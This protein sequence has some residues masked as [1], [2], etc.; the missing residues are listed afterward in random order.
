MFVECLLCVCPPQEVNH[1]EFEPD[2]VA[3]NEV[4]KGSLRHVKPAGPKPAM[5]KYL[6]AVPKKPVA[7]SIHEEYWGTVAEGGGPSF[8]EDI[9][10]FA[11]DLESSLFEEDESPADEFALLKRARATPKGRGCYRN[12]HL[13]QGSWIASVIWDDEAK[14]RG[15]PS[16][17][18]LDVTADR[19]LLGGRS[20]CEQM[21]SLHTSGSS[22]FERFQMVNESNYS[23]AMRQ[24]TK[25]NI[26]GPTHSIPALSLEF[27]GEEPKRGAALEWLHR[28]IVE[29]SKLKFDFINPA[30]REIRR[31][32]ELL[33][34]GGN[35]NAYRDAAD[36]SAGVEDRIVL[37]EY[38][39][40][41]PVVLNS[42]GMSSRIVTYMRHDADTDPTIK[43]RPDGKVAIL[44]AVQTSPFAPVDI[45]PDRPV[46]A[47]TNNLFIAAMGYQ[48]PNPTDFLLVRRK[49]TNSFVI[50]DLA[51]EKLHGLYAVGS[52][53]PRQEM[54]E[55]KEAMDKD[56]VRRRI[57]AYLIRKLD[58]QHEGWEEITHDDIEAAFSNQNGHTLK[59]ILRETVED[60]DD[61]YRLKD[62][63]PS[64]SEA[65]LRTYLTPEQVALHNSMLA[66][67]HHI[68]TDRI[69]QFI[70]PSSAEL[71]LEQ[72]HGL[73]MQMVVQKLIA[74]L[75]DTP[76]YRTTAILNIS[77]PIRR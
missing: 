55:P 8:V 27:D 57:R 32:D 54:P 76:W 56:L 24:N 75:K 25:G 69:R 6:V 1:E 14:L 4:V 63:A 20:V 23:G 35:I 2:F 44:S 34:R 21:Q 15:P 66:G 7:A 36:L 38:M 70:T 17:L 53:V 64:V 42:V 47:L 62:G 73:Q 40:R 58:E 49:K 13:L 31:S 51:N 71:A 29:L 65:E 19:A 5:S 59:K 41:H 37:C 30:P 39:E 77:R 22:A 50:R 67:L 26:E 10:D 60:D 72:L 28:P 68:H 43:P 74:E 18:V 16:R 33:V 9:D 45:P 46:T 48:A 3:E 61:R 12:T 11:A 52:L